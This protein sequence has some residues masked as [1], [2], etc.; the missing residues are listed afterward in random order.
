M[1]KVMF[2]PTEIKILS[3]ALKDD[4]RVQQH[5]HYLFN[6][7]YLPD[8][9]QHLRR[10]LEKLLD[11]NDGKDILATEYHKVIK[12]DGKKANIGI[13][14]LVPKYKKEIDKYLKTISKQDEDHRKS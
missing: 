10:K 6:C 14:R 12:I 9:V 8:I 3:F 5:Y 13:Y 7:H 1:K 4:D 11:K 2:T